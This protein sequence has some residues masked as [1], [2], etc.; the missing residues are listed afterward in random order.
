VHPL[1]V[2]PLR[3]RSDDIPILAA[4]FCDVTGRRLGLGPVDL[5]PPGLAAL[6]SHP[7]P[8]NVR[9]LDSVLWRA[10]LRAAGA[11][12]G[13]P[14]VLTTTDLGSDFGGALSAGGAP[15]SVELK[16]A[17]REFQRSLIRRA[18]VASGGNWAA[19]ARSLGMHRSN[20]HHLAARLGLKQR[21]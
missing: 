21:G 14:I 13:R 2:P 9:E 16:E 11:G 19:A 10:A 7:W 20:F 3:E 4:H 12:R 1:H 17:T 18:L 5:E 6:R 15:A 8:G